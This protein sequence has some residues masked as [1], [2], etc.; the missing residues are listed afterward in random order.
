MK[1]D[2]TQGPQNTKEESCMPVD[3]SLFYYGRIYHLLID[4]A[5]KEAR[6]NILRLI[7]AGSKVLDVGCGTG[8]LALLLRA[9]KRCSV[10][11]VDLSLRMISFAQDSNPY[12]DVSF[13]HGDARSILDFEENAFDYAVMCQ[14]IHELPLNTQLQAVSELTRLGRRTI[15]QDSTV[16]LPRN[17]TGLAIRMAEAT[18]GRDHLGNFK[19]YVAA[20]GIT[21][22]L[23]KAELQSRIAKRVVF[24][25]D[26]QQLVV[27]DLE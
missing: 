3:K 14:V 4:P 11:G 19:A 6:D 22:I 17:V 12:D 25:H 26:C 8:Q 21:G 10:V 18:F 1:L 15:I 27:L 23:E 13:L 5:L 9:Q 16:P 7:P 20:G 2:V 24:N